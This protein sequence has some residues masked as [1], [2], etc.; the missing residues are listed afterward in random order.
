ML[1]SS[2]FAQVLIFRAAVFKH[3]CFWAENI[4]ICVAFI[5]VDCACVWR[6]KV[7]QGQGTALEEQILT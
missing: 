7:Y 4:S 2:S 1:S 3:G 5:D 6:Q